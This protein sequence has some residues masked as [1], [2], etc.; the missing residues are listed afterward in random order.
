MVDELNSTSSERL[1]TGRQNIVNELKL[2]RFSWG[3]LLCSPLWLLTHG[4]FMTAIVWGLLLWIYPPLVVVI[5]V[6]MFVKG[7][8]WSWRS[9]QRW[10][11]YHEFYQTERMWDWWIV[12]NIYLTGIALPL[13]G[14]A[15]LWVRF[16]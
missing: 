2:S 5:H 7:R 6:L 11:N 15:Y 1:V 4:F 14:I 3:A 10:P 9:G 8:E 16:Y 13:I 12:F